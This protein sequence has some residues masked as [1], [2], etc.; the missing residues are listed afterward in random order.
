MYSLLDYIFHDVD[1]A[2][3]KYGNAPA[4][5]LGIPTT[6]LGS[7][8]MSVGARAR[9]ARSPDM[10]SLEGMGKTLQLFKSS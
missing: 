6:I 4:S 3:V 9:G 2:G 7:I 8:C 1:Q 10:C 5:A